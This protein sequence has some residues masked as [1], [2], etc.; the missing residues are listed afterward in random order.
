VVQELT[1][2]HSHF[3]FLHLH[4]HCGNRAS[5]NE[6]VEQVHVQ[7]FFSACT[8]SDYS[9]VVL[10]LPAVRRRRVRRSSVVVVLLLR[11]RV[12]QPQAAGPLPLLLLRRRCCP[13]IFFGG[14]DPSPTHHAGARRTAEN[15]KPGTEEKAKEDEEADNKQTGERKKREGGAP[16]TQRVLSRKLVKYHQRKKRDYNIKHGDELSERMSSRGASLEAPEGNELQDNGSRIDVT[17]KSAL[18]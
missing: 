18:E 14:D 13:F 10:A 8:T 5:V 6:E 12:V 9:S 7:L 11:W 15:E 2:L 3:A 4:T 16:R 1:E 17:T